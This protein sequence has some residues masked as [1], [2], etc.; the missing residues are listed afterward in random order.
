MPQCRYSIILLIALSLLC[1]L[2]CTEYDYATPDTPANLAGYARHFKVAPSADVQGVYY[3]ADE[4]GADAIYQLR[5]EAEASTVEAIKAALGLTKEV[6]PPNQSV[7]RDDLT[8]W[9]SDRIENLRP[10]AKQFPGGSGW[11][12]LW[13]DEEA[14]EVFYLQFG[15]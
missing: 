14:R 4:F 11:Y 15:G 1:G 9:P 3:Y 13:H 7:A 8:W 5:F 12:L 2:G 10:Y 6:T